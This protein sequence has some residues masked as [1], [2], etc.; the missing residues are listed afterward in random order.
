M[1]RLGAG[2]ER[3]GCLAAEQRNVEDAKAQEPPARGQGREAD[4]AAAEAAA[5]AATSRTAPG[6]RKRVADDDRA[7]TISA[8]IVQSIQ[9]LRRRKQE[10]RLQEEQG[11]TSPC[12]FFE[13]L[14]STTRIKIS[15]GWKE[16]L[17]LVDDS[18]IFNS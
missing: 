9:P 18:D 5:A 1:P 4:C 10:G 15:Q 14:W 12:C 13:N 2:R 11:P 8:K 16:A 17:A 7:T 6:S 3:V